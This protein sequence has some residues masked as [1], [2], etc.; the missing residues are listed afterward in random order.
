MISIL[1]HIEDEIVFSNEHGLRHPVAIYN[2]SSTKVYSSFEKIIGELQRKN[3][4]NVLLSDLHLKLVESL[5]AYVDDVY[6]IVKC[7]IPSTRV[8]SNIIFNDKWLTKIYKNEV[9]FFKNNI[10]EYRNV[11]ANINN[12]V[13]HNHG[14]YIQI[15]M[16]SIV[17]NS[18]GFFIDGVDDMGTVIPFEDIHPRFQGAYTATSYNHSIR[19]LLFS[20]LA[21]DYYAADFLYKVVHAEH[22]MKLKRYSVE[23]TSSK[24]LNEIVIEI[25]KLSKMYFPNE[26]HDAVEI[27]QSNREATLVYP[28]RVTYQNKLLQ[29]KNMSF[30]CKHN[31]DGYSNSYGIPYMK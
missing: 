27:K 19:K 1:S 4:D 24:R 22:S 18:S 8:K 16:K 15:E 6:C 5:T 12:R 9:S 21:I 17:G 30:T 31:G 14:R 2:L 11:F 23:E 20:Y 29:P 7:F 26:F 28:A 13:K 3:R 25:D 10:T